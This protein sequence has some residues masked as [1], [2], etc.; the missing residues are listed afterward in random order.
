MKSI[1]VKIDEG[2]LEK[3]IEDHEVEPFLEESEEEE[4][5]KIRRGWRTS[6]LTFKNS[7]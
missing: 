7:F 4:P 3:R 2:L 1:D 5:E 6:K